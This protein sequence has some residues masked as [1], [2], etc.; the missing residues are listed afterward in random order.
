MKPSGATIRRFIVVAI[1][2]LFIFPVSP[3]NALTGR[4]LDDG[5]DPVEGAE[6]KLLMGARQLDTAFTDGDGAYDIDAA[7]INGTIIV[8]A[9]LLGTPGVDYLPFKAD[10][11][12][13]TASLDATLLPA[14]SILV[15]GDLLYVD[16][17]NLALQAE[18]SILGDGNE[19]LEFFG[20]PLVYGG[21]NEM[22]VL[23]LPERHLLVPA[24]SVVRVKLNSSFLL[25]STVV[26]RGFITEEI[27]TSPQGL[28]QS[29]DV[30]EY[31][32]PSNFVLTYMARD[33]L[34][35]K[36]EE[37]SGYGFYL[38]RQE[39]AYSTALLQL[40]DSR[41]FYDEGIYGDSFE[42]LKL[43]YIKLVYTLGELNRMY[44]DARLSVYILIT[45]MAASSMITGYLLADGV[46]QLG[47]DAVIY[48]VCLAALFKVYPGSKIVPF[49]SFVEIAAAA[50]IALALIGVIL[51][52]FFSVGSGGRVHTRN[53]I[54]PIFSIAKRSLRRRKM[55]FL[56]TLISISLLVMSF[57][58]LTSF[59][60]GY[61]LIEGS[62]SKTGDWEGVSIREGSWSMSDPTFILF[63]EAE[64]GWLTSQPGVLYTSSKA[65]N[66]PQRRSFLSIH[67][68][69]MLGVIG[70]DPEED[71]T[72]NLSSIMLRGTL[73][74]K[75]GL[76]IPSGLADQLS[77][78]IGDTVGIFYLDLEVQGV[79]DE[80]ALNGLR[81][82]DGARYVPDKWVNTNPE[83]EVAV[84]AL[85]ECEAR[86]TIIL[87]VGTASKIPMVGIQRIAIGLDEDV[88]AKGFAEKLAL[89]RGYMSYAS[90]AD[91]FV[92]LRL[93]NYFEGRGL[94]LI[95]PWA[96]VVLNV[97]VTMLNALYERRSEIE[98]LSSVG[99][100]P[101][102]VSAIFVAEATITGFIAG[103][104]GYLV[105][106]GLY[107]GMALLNLGLM[108]HQKVS[109]VWSLASIALAISAVLTGAFAALRNSVVITPS[110]MRRWRIDREVGGFQDPY[111][112]AIPLKL[113]P[114]EV[115]QY[116]DY[117]V[118]NLKTLEN[119]PTQVTSS[120]KIQKVG[121][122][123]TVHF[124]YKSLQATTG[125]FY[126]RNELK[127]APLPN[128]EYG[129]TLDSLGDIKWVHV[130]GSL[131]R[132]LTMDYSTVR[133]D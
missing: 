124:V 130:A 92:S 16:T 24:G 82:L 10:V 125:N 85:D 89:E 107:K 96:I 106:L 3:V 30:R 32:L 123:R 104:L 53:L 110:L 29:I 100:N 116:I 63:S 47:L 41:D 97:V 33:A 23:K 65:E 25:S 77:I 80:A 31:N 126:T 20:I 133:A 115:D 109:A 129:A 57:V 120:I 22:S 79:F 51:P 94:S 35:E 39:G 19:T 86:E 128:G 38:T 67:G 59:S 84:W 61:G 40:S 118:A 8:Y 26:R 36:L 98:I 131:V 73:P 68:E 37:M 93:G 21:S 13:A 91:A 28:T 18:Y 105:G 108:V 66:V 7:P 49:T 81:D 27:R 78:A 9:D 45:F 58:T 60:E 1:I 102:Q 42:S 83:G 12:V 55:R 50:F 74:D 72:V 11:T 101:A 69:P 4:V 54:I 2:V 95:I 48:S 56:L 103:G 71:D 17:E 52:R 43:G 132:K 117:M 113:E 119:H 99:L 15:E 5:G 114:E 87:R 14:S 62:Y 90:T 70:V 76:L 75:Y 121:D 46:K 112:I 111:R 64:R 88:D 127:V 34:G 122:E 44:S 6:V